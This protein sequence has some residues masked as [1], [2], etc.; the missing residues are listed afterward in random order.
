MPPKRVKKKA[1]KET[2]DVSDISKYLMAHILIESRV[3]M[4]LK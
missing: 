4:K 1:R 3:Q 2:T